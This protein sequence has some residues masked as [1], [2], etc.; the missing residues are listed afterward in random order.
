MPIVAFSRVVSLNIIPAIT[1]GV[2]KLF[3]EVINRFELSGPF[4]DFYMSLKESFLGVNVY[5]FKNSLVTLIF[6]IIICFSSL[7][8]SRLWCRT[9]C[10]LGAMYAFIAKYSLFGRK[11]E[12]CTNCNICVDKCRMAAINKDNT[13]LKSE[14]ILCMDCIYDCS[15]QV[16]IFSFSSFKNKKEKVSFDNESNISRKDFLF[17]ILSSFS[18]PSFF[19]GLKKEQYKEIEIIRPPGSLKEK[20]FLNACIRCGNCMKVC[21]TNG[22]QPSLL[23]SGVQGL[24]TPVLIPEIGYCEYNCTL[25]GEACPTGAISRLNLKE[26][27]KEKIGLA[28]VDKGRC[29][30]WNYHEECLVCEE[31][32]PVADKAIKVELVSVKNGKKIFAPVVDKDLCIG[33]GICQNKCPARP[34]RAIRVKGIR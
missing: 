32:C 8:I 18:I 23:H 19:K 11:A 17:L 9:I 22:L 5:F 29:I 33:C 30:A 10:P 26:K 4:Y 6:F 27:H 25:C 7:F 1:L 15:R 21:I 3:I 34:K 20:S 28:K 31:H 13:Y 24:W 12:N 2:N 14:C 16:A